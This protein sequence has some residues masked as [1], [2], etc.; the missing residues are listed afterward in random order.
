M[1]L[2]SGEASRTARPRKRG[3]RL[4]WL[5]V[6]AAL[7][8]VVIGVPYVAHALLNPWAISLTGRPTLTGY[9]QGQVAFAPGDQRSVVLHIRS[10]PR[11]GRCPNCSPIDGAVR[12]CAGARPM[13]YELTGRVHDR[14]ARGFRLSV[15]PGETGGR[16]LRWFDGTWPGGDQISVSAT[17]LVIDA[18]GVS[19][20][21]HQPAQP[22]RFAMRRAAK[23]DFTAAC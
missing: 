18:D 13:T 15:S 19:R 3:R 9:W 14:H 8:A 17:I 10:E 4:L 22:V 6:A 20:S 2:P 16:Y 21:D 5:L 1:R 23:A 11:T 12:V 7:A